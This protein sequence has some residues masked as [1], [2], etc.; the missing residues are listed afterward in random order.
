MDARTA[1]FLEHVQTGG[2]VEAT[3][4]LPDDY[5]Q[6]LLKFVEMHANCGIYGADVADLLAVVARTPSDVRTVMVIGHEPTMSVDHP[7]PGRE[8]LG[9][10]LRW[11]GCRRSSPPTA[12]PCCAP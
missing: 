9:C 4:W 7:D 11:N 8:R 3:D 1:E 12:S 6:K 2:Q 10:A 5:R